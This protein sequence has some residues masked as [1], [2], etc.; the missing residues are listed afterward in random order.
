MNTRY[1]THIV[2]A[3]ITVVTAS[4]AYFSAEKTSPSSA[5]TTREGIKR[6]EASRSTDD[7][8][9]NVGEITQHV[10]GQALKNEEARVLTFQVLTEANRIKRMRALCD[11]L[12][13]I[14]PENWRGVI[15]AFIRQSTKEFRT[16]SVEWGLVIERVGEVAGAEAVSE[17][18]V[19]G[20]KND[21]DRAKSL[22]V[23]WAAANPAAAGEWFKSQPPE[24]QNQLMGSYLNGLSR[25]DPQAALSL[26]LLQP[27]DAQAKTIEK[28]IDNAIQKGGFREAEQLL[29]PLMGRSDIEDGSRGKLFYELA[30]RRIEVSKVTDNPIETLDWFAS[31]LRYPKSPA[32]Q[33]ATTELFA[34]ASA[35]NP[36]AAMD[37]LDQHADVIGQYHGNIAYPLVAATM[38]VK[39]PEQFDAWFAKNPDHPH[40][41]K[42]AETATMSLIYSGKLDQAAQMIGAIRDPKTAEKLQAT[43]DKQVNRKAAGPK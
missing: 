7:P 8:A 34:N 19:A 12:E 9:A 1:L 26:V 3:L 24:I 15:D 20:K 18:L 16:N 37:W 36:K 35:R 40:R 21:L 30:K 5:P 10:S 6:A 23:G 29:E 17:A 25:T 28:I 41:E 42:I 32:G 38:L 11:M 13:S 43:L 14:S 2:W 22:L 31:Y 33:S 39:S 4:A 27:Q